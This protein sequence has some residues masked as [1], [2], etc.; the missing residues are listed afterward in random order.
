MNDT[1][2]VNNMTT[3]QEIHAKAGKLLNQQ[4]EK[5]QK[6][7]D[8]ADMLKGST[9]QQYTQ[10]P[11]G[12]AQFFLKN[13]SISIPDTISEVFDENESNTTFQGILPEIGRAWFTKD[14]VLYLWDYTEGTDVYKYD[15]QDQIISDVGLVR[16][17]PGVF[18]DHIQ[19]V[20]VVATPLEI[21]LLGVGLQSSPS[22]PSR[23]SMDLF[24]TEL[25]VSSDD[26][27]MVSVQGTDNGRIFMCGM[28]GHLY[29]FIYNH[30]KSW[31][32][33][34]SL[35][36][37]TLSSASYYL[38]PKFSIF[39]SSSPGFKYIA[40]DDERNVLYAFS[41]KSMIEVFYLGPTKTEF[42][43]IAKNSDIANSARLMCRQNSTTFVA[44]DFDIEYLHV[45]SISEST[46]IHLVAV[47]R[48]GYRLY[49]THQRDALRNTFAYSSATSS[50][51]IKMIPNALELVHVRLPPRMDQVNQST[52]PYP[53]VNMSYYDYGVLLASQTYDE[54]YDTIYMSSGTVTNTIQPLTTTTTTT[55]GYTSQQQQQQQQPFLETVSEVKTIGK[56]WAMAEAD[57]INKRKYPVNDI[58]SQL[59]DPPRRFLVLSD[60][61]LTFINKQR[62]VDTLYHLLLAINDNYE[63][64]QSDLQTFFDQ[65]GRTQACAMCLSIICASYAYGFTEQE[66][67]GKQAKQV[68]FQ[69]GGHP[70][71]SG[72]A[73]LVGNYL[74]RAVGQ[75]D[76]QYSSKHDGLVLYFAR[77]VSDVWKTKVFKINTEKSQV[78]FP[79]RIQSSL[80]SVQSNLSRL[81]AFMDHNPELHNT[82]SIHDRKFQPND[83]GVVQL[84]LA[85]QQSVH[86]LYDL[87]R[88]C[89]EAISFMDFVIDA[90]IKDVLQCV[91]DAI[92]T[93]MME[94][95]LESMLTSSHGVTLKRTMVVSAIYRYG[96]THIHAGY[97]VVTD[98]LQR[99][100]P[101]FFGAGDM[102]FYKGMESLTCAHKADV[103]YE[104]VMA[105]EESLNYFT[106]SADTIPDD[107][108]VEI[109]EEYR[110]QSYYLGV[111]K[112]ALERAKKLD[113]QQQGLAYIENSG[114]FGTTAES[115]PSDDP[116]VQTY[117]LDLKCYNQI[118]ECLKQV[119]QLQQGLKVVV[120]GGR[121]IYVTDPDSLAAA[122][123]ST[124]LASDDK[125]FH[126][127]LYQWYLIESSNDSGV[128]TELLSMNPKYIV[129]FMKEYVDVFVGM[130][131]LWQY[132]RRREQ[133]YDA[134]LYLEALA[135][136]KPDIST[137]ERMEYLGL[138]I[139]NARSRDPK[140]V[141]TQEVVQLLQRLEQKME[142]LRMASL[143]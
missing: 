128:L 88:Q 39:N 6:Q 77:L 108:F 111:V 138:A 120:K 110:Y 107:E 51:T 95:S 13:D 106:A 65:Y 30:P 142:Q 92:R 132:Y 3:S 114:S 49:F 59:M 96:S 117:R 102:A 76:I 87:L 121:Q 31:F 14:N 8:L 78:D 101:F 85:E 118:L 34:C 98:F 126:Y 89:I 67:I 24:A 50:S 130:D 33:S 81:K 99:K 124:A 37:L 9:S 64:S 28:N 72:P 71:A 131:F 109:C 60:R 127:T 21:I 129:T 103:D 91:P 113:P 66:D 68:F 80:F 27:Q 12:N 137:N 79:G 46:K 56:V 116:R 40:I 5:D 2:K 41:D 83:H 32:S 25:C 70:S 73:P 58:A 43:S 57:T 29:E 139:V 48:R 38:L 63:N 26:I 123:L 47:T 20:L 17:K 22:E 135:S 82:A 53:E 44:S 140:H 143:Q 97:D 141:D 35:H 100:C 15:D 1:A 10:S 19:Y 16:P 136:E 122:V 62:P 23:N 86:E 7:I 69:F 54:H 84:L 74:G 119:R 125:L 133:Y 90:N 93:E 75:T 55:T 45:I 42:T 94:L 115:A 52:Q 105:L 61:G 134:A 4:I 18:G 36:C 104:R 112:L 11:M